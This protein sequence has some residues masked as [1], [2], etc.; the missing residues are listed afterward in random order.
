MEGLKVPI[1]LLALIL[2]AFLLV[3]APWKPRTDKPSGPRPEKLPDI[4]TQVRLARSAFE[5]NNFAEMVKLLEPVRLADDPNVQSLLGFAYAGLKDFPAAIEAFEKALAKKRDV[6]FGYSLAFL[7]ENILD[8]EKARALYLDLGTAPLGKQ[9]VVKV[10]LGAARCSLALGDQA[11]ALK[12][13][14]EVLA[15]DPTREE[16]YVEILKLMR[17]ARNGKDI[18]KLR[19]T[20]DLFHS[21]SFQYQFAL[22]TLYYELG[23]FPKA[24][25]AIQAAMALNPKNSSP[26]YFL[27]QILRKSK[28]VEEAVA[29]LEKFYAVNPFLPYIFFEA[30][31]DAK[32]QGRLDLAFKFFRSSVTMDRSLLGREDRGTLYAIE[33]YLK[34]KGTPVEREFFQALFDFANGD[35]QKAMNKVKVVLPKIRDP[36]LKDDAERIARESYAIL[37]REDQYNAYQARLRQEQQMA[38]SALQASMNARR[39][40]VQQQP[41]TGSPAARAEELKRTAMLNPNDVKL[42]YSTAL[43]LSRLGDLEGAKLF[44]RETIRLDPNIP[45]AYYSL[46]RLSHHQGKSE[47]AAEHLAEAL[48]RSPNNSQALSFSALIHSELGDTDRAQKEAEGAIASNP[49]NG[50]A[51]L[52]L[53]RLYASSQ[54]D[55]ALTEVTFG[56]AVETDPRRIAEFNQLKAR[57]GSH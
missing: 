43:Q 19:E 42:Q 32:D 11:T 34:E 29:E 37:H 4:A 53:A 39:N 49:N 24:T 28:K 40:N 10:K 45:E 47:E 6:S 17:L 5:K 52:V 25:K 36:R 15:L 16:P 12:C 57:L 2:A 8:M 27:Y 23:D 14:K 20:G 56:L 3:Y 35:F 51:R 38:M 55:K 21:K 44:L 50:E 22:G 13:F 26:F 18:D 48:R 33:Q 41:S 30:A 7:Y 1:L 9:M 54:P 31:L 46:A